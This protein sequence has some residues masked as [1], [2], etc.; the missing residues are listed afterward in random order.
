MWRG[1]RTAQALAARNRHRQTFWTARPSSLC[2]SRAAVA[3]AD[4]G[5]IHRAICLYGLVSG[6]VR[7]GKLLRT[8]LDFD[9][10]TICAR[11]AVEAALKATFTL[12]CALPC[13]PPPWTIP[14]RR[15]ADARAFP[16]SPPLGSPARIRL[17]RSGSVG[18]RPFA[19]PGC[20]RA[21]P[22][23]HPVRAAATSAPRASRRM[24]RC[25]RCDRGRSRPRSRHGRWPASPGCR[26][27]RWR[28]GSRV[29]SR[30]LPRDCS[31]RCGRPV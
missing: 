19:A 21:R 7:R 29:A 10:A 13:S 20:G 30:S 4:P 8:L 1:D 12:R 22:T 28:H 2:G 9:E 16:L 6:L 15:P 23:G 14:K 18:A 17:T 31:P 24:R 11:E 5:H 26:A 25:P 27:Q 3:A